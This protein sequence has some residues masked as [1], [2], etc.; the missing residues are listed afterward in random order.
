MIRSHLLALLGA[1]IT[2]LAFPPF[3]PGF[4]V[5]VGVAL[6]LLALEG[7]QSGR[8]GFS[9]GLLYGLVFFGGL[10]W[11]MSLLDPLA[12]I[13]IPVQGLFLGAYGWWLGRHWQSQPWRWLALAVGGWALMEIIRYRFP[14]GGQEWGALGYAL[15]DIGITRAPAAVVGT[16]GL[17]VIVV[18]LSCLA[19]LRISGRW[20]K[21]L[22]WLLLIPVLLAVAS[23]PADVD[24]VDSLPVAIV[25]GS[26]PCPFERCPPNERLRTF[27]QHLALTRTIDAGEAQLIVW[28]ESS[29]GSTN[30]DPV[31]NEAIREAIGDEA[32]RIGAQVMVGGDRIVDDDHF[33]NANVLI[34]PDGQIVGEY[35]KQH[36]VPFGEYV[37]A[38]PLFEW[39]PVLR[40]RVPRDMIRGDGPEVFDLGVVQLGSVISWEGGFSR[41]ARQHRMAGANLL[42]VATNKASYGAEAPTSD[43]FIGMTRMRAVELGVPVLHAAV[44]GKSTIVDRTGELGQ[45]TATGESVVIHGAA[46]GAVTTLYARTGD[47]LMIVAAVVGALVWLAVSPLVGSARSRSTEE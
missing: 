3:G 5:F 24:D 12:L 13:L 26:T 27:E 38:R 25:Q 6:F 34:G 10:M 37:P 7:A 15:S 41:Y 32:R 29:T 40:E 33:I 28:P 31:L 42:V 16:S 47:L 30:A 35:R 1:I 11:W 23:V 22:L 2:V 20:S 17:T 39:I 4:L 18:L 8:E 21:Q 9:I 43:Q 46:S 45:V 44:T 19:A 36:P 14:L